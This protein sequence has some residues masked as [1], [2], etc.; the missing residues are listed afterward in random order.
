MLVI[1]AMYRVFVAGKLM[2]KFLSRAAEE[3]QQRQKQRK[4]TICEP[5]LQEAMK[6][7]AKL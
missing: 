6:E 3:Y 5:L 1:I 4:D 7:G 2:Y